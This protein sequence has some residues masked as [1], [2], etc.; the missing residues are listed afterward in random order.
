MKWVVLV[1]RLLLGFAFFAASLAYFL[2]AMPEEAPPPEGSAAA[3]FMAALIPTGYMTAIKVIEL[4]GGALLLVGRWP[5]IGLTLVTP[6]AVNILFFELFVVHSPGPGVVLVLLA[7]FL[8][9]AYRSHFRPVFAMK[10]T[11]G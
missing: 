1:A 3:H 10:P 8:V 2:K 11:I 4:L 9:W 6:V 7:A 5:L